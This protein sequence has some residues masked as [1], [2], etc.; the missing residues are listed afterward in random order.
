MYYKNELGYT[1]PE[2]CDG[3]MIAPPKVHDVV[4]DENYPYLQKGFWFLCKRVICWIL[5][6]FLMFWV[7]RI[8]HGLRIHGK[9]NIRK[10]RKLFK[11]KGVISVSNHVYRWD[12]MSV[13][14][15]IRPRMLFFPVWAD[16]VEG[17][18]AMWIRM[19]G[20]LPVP[21]SIKGMKRFK[22]DMEE[23]FEK[24]KWVHY[25]PEASMWFYYPDLRPFK[26]SAF[27]YAVKYDC[28]ILPMAFSFR[29][30]W[31]ITKWFTKNP[32]VDLTIGQPIFPDQSLSPVAATKELIE[33]SAHVMQEM[34]GIHP[35]D[36][37]YSLDQNPA[38]YKATM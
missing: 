34:M 15:A 33:K 17:P 1:Y 22:A 18:D 37:T 31:G 21:A 36:P 12:T 6:N 16:N 28:P 30:R 8:T 14:K 24:K 20:G 27:Q 23:V 35:G 13:C 32:F 10:N 26:K 7:L 38:N 11:E 19:A 9:K 5:F 3:H 2:R 4:L 25:F 29:P